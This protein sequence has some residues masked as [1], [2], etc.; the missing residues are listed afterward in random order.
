TLGSTAAVRV[1][2][3]DLN[4]THVSNI[5][6]SVDSVQASLVGMS[7]AWG[8]S[9]INSTVIAE[10]AGNVDLDASNIS[11]TARGEARKAAG[12][13]SVVSGSGGAFNAAAASNTINATLNTKVD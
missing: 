6:T 7:G 12:G 1:A 8:K 2:T 9:T 4:A 10:V 11:I 5:A 13:H 3:L